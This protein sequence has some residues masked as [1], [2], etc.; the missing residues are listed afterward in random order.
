VQ[1]LCMQ[2]SINRLEMRRH[3]GMHGLALALRQ[4]LVHAL[5]DQRVQK[6]VALAIHW[7]QQAML[8][9]RIELVLR[10]GHE[11]VDVGWREGLTQHGGQA[12]RVAVLRRDIIEPHLQ[13]VLKVVRQMRVAVGHEQLR[14]KE[15]VALR[16][17]HALLAPVCIDMVELAG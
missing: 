2:R 17:L 4:G 10:G 15:W 7:A 11:G 9:Q 13:Q 8:H 3:L 12:Q 16:T 6:V 14:Q 1:V 5:P